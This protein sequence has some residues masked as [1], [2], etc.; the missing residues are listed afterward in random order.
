[1][2]REIFA[3]DIE[4]IEKFIEIDN[5]FGCIAKLHPTTKLT[6]KRMFNN[7]DAHGYIYD[8]GTFQI[9]LFLTQHAGNEIEDDFIQ[10]LRMV[11]KWNY[12]N[13]NIN[14][15]DAL[16]IVGNKTK[17]YLKDRNK[18]IRMAVFS[19]EKVS[20]LPDQ[21]ILEWYGDNIITIYNSVGLK[22]TRFE[23]YWII[24]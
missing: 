3:D 14:P 7:E 8:D 15:K 10:C 18:K 20:T 16:Y 23:T 11:I 2:W 19:E 1:M 13:P 17:E 9:L 22:A 12:Y 4:G 5:S 6:L 24:E 21:H